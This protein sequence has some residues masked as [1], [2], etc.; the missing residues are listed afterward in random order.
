MATTWTKK[1]SFADGS[2]VLVG[3]LLIFLLSPYLLILRFLE[4]PFQWQADEFIWA[5]RNSLVQ[6]FFSAICSVVLGVFGALVLVSWAPVS[7]V[8]RWLDT[9]MVLPGFLPPIFLMIALLSLGSEFP[10]GVIG[11][12]VAHA[13]ACFGLVATSLARRMEQKL[14]AYSQV[15]AVLGATRLM[16]IRWVAWPLMRKDLAS[17]FILVFLVCLGSFSIPFVMGTGVGITLEVLI[18][19]KIRNA[20]AWGQAVSYSL[21]QSFL[22]LIL[23]WPRQKMLN[24]RSVGGASEQIVPTKAGKGLLQLLPMPMGAWLVLIIVGALFVSYLRSVY[25]GF[26]R[27]EALQPIL[28]AAI[29]PMMATFSF[30]AAVGC[31]LA[32]TALLTIYCLPNRRW[33]NFLMSYLAPSTALSAFAFLTLGGASGVVRLFL[34]AGVLV[35]LNITALMRMGLIRQLKDLRLQMRL[36]EILGAGRALTFQKVVYPQ[37]ISSVLYSSGIGAVWAAGDFAVTR[38]F[39]RGDTMLGL[40]VQSLASGYRLELAGAMSVVLLLVSAAVFLA[41]LGASYVVDKKS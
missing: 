17:A 36:A 20:G 12:V 39:T 31:L 5:L 41:F 32:L 9:L 37:M 1:L 11:I 40:V 29:A 22:V 19:E 10:R 18:Y 30:A 2:L 8:R 14:V 27:W 6:A 26:S 33:E 15:G 24:S 38:L 23:V 28:V 16:F 34:A 7:P 13:L 4:A 3:L 25:L 21:A 35:L